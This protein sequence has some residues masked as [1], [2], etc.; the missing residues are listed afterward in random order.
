MKTIIQTTAVLFIIFFTAYS[1]KKGIPHSG[2]PKVTTFATGFNNPRGLKFGPGGYLY[3][4]EAG[5]GGEAKTTE[6]CSGITPPGVLGSPTGGSIS[7]VSSG[8]IRTIVTNKLP[9]STDP[10]GSISGVSDVAFCGNTL[11]ALISGG[12]C[13]NGVP[14]VPNGILKI[15]SS[16][17]YSI[18]ADLGTWQHAHPVANPPLD[19]APDG[20]WYSMVNVGNV[21]YALDANHGE[22]VKVTTDGTI[23]RVVDFS[24]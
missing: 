9:T 6:I 12:A 16:E 21:F 18:I 3:V 15:N 23:T 11:Y 10:F 14:D 24:K 4:A 19:F 2:A 20:V 5:L 1:C 17:S 7:K 22:L 8:G 13:E